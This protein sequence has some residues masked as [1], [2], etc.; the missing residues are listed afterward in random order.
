MG[1]KIMIIRVV[2]AMRDAMS[3]HR[4]KMYRTGIDLSSGYIPGQIAPTYPLAAVTGF[5][6]R[7]GLA[8]AS[9]SRRR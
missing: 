9:P 7:A 6:P 4:I 3:D 5:Q 1:F 2:C 8:S